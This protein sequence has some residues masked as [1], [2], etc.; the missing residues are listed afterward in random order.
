[1]LINSE[2]LKI[3]SFIE[4]LIGIQTK[5]QYRTKQKPNDL[6]TFTFFF[7]NNHKKYFSRFVSHLNFL[8]GESSSPGLCLFC[9]EG[10]KFSLKFW[11]SYLQSLLS[12]LL[13][14]LILFIWHTKS[15]I[16]YK[17]ESFLHS[18]LSVPVLCPNFL[19]L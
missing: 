18:L 2:F 1:M 4:N 14:A 3:S 17:I 12:S 9:F 16:T 7:F 5:E 13:F 10:L 6:F 8:V 11:L 15:F 19:F